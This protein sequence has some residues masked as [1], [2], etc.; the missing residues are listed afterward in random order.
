MGVVVILGEMGLSSRLTVEAQQKSWNRSWLICLMDAFRFRV[1]TMG[2]GV[3]DC[4][5]AVM[6]HD[7]G[8]FDLDICFGINT[9]RGLA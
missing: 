8:T 6:P 4:S 2:G 1:Y 5:L 7:L 9:V 3:F